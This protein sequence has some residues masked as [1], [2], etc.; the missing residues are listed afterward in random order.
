MNRKLHLNDDLKTI[1][2][3]IYNKKDDSE[4]KKQAFLALKEAVKNMKPDAEDKHDTPDGIAGRWEQ[5]SW[6]HEYYATFEVAKNN[7]EYSMKVV[8]KST[9]LELLHPRRLFNISFDGNIWRFCSDWGEDGMANFELHKIHNNRF[10][11]DWY[12]GSRRGSMSIWIREGTGS[13]DIS[14]GE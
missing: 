10:E 2:Q 11:G 7:G 12:R 8:A 1:V 14:T 4:E 9:E 13:A 5:Y 6:R 3:E